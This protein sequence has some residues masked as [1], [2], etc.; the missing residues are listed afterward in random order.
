[1]LARNIEQVILSVKEASA[2][3]EIDNLK[4]LKGYTNAYRISDYRIGLYFTE[5]IIEFA[6]LLNRKD[7]YRYFP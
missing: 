6:C 1:M 4:K 5:G 2:L 7:V 3:S